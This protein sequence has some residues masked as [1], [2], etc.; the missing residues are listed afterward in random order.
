MQCF[1]Q[2]QQT[3]SSF[4]SNIFALLRMIQLLFI[5]MSMS[6][7]KSENIIFLNQ[8]CWE[9]DIQRIIFQTLYTQTWRYTHIYLMKFGFLWC[10]YAEITSKKNVPFKKKLYLLDFS[11]RCWLCCKFC[12]MCTFF[13]TVL[14]VHYCFTEFLMTSQRTQHSPKLFKLGASPA[15]G[16]R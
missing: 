12:P 6:C 7:R 13:V 14:K 8:N 10:P 5:E 1:S 4:V 15:P 11:A 16:K 2:T 3:L 9:N